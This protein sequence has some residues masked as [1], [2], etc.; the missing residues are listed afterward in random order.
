MPRRK[1]LKPKNTGEIITEMGHLFYDAR[2]GKLDSLDASRMAAILTA[3]R[4]TLEASDLENR[5]RELE[6]K[7]DE[8]RG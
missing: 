8:S 4:Q 7:V 1:V 2:N 6:K 5:I 3:L